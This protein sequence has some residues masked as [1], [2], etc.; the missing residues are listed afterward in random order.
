MKK[1][2][3]LFALILFVGAFSTTVKS[4]TDFQSK[5]DSLIPRQVNLEQ[6]GK[7]L[8]AAESQ[9][10]IKEWY[11]NLRSDGSFQGYSYENA[12]CQDDVIAGFVKRNIYSLSYPKLGLKLDIFDRPSKLYS[13]ETVN[14][15]VSVMGIKIGDTS[16]KVQAALGKGEWKS[17][18][19]SDE[20]SLIYKKKGVEFIF[21]RNL[22]AKKHPK[23][24]AP[25]S[26]V[27]KMQIFDSET[28]FTSCK[29]KSR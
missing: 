5:F 2:Q 13:V 25:G 23:K 11:G 1:L 9:T 6:I 19:A 17:I 28:S 12:P 4:Q 8:G 21:P 7:I 3:I 27:I 14:P 10:L 24:L 16:E 22:N 18:R 26:T 29:K 20:L 15:D